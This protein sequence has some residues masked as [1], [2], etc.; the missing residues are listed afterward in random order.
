MFGLRYINE[1]VNNLEEV[2]VLRMANIYRWA[3]K[4][5]SAFCLFVL[6][7]SPFYVDLS[8][9]SLFTK[10][11]IFGLLAMSLDLLVG[12]TGLWALGDLIHFRVISLLDGD[13]DD[14]IRHH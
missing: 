8:I 1:D 4:V 12:Y 3:P 11:L 2:T 6:W 9:L 5:V 14:S 7:V 10:I 13:Y